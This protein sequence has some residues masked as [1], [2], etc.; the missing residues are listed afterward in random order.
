MRIQ[1]RFLTPSPRILAAGV[2]TVLL[3]GTAVSQQAAAPADTLEEVTVTGVR[4]SLERSLLLKKDSIGVLDA[5]SSEDIGKFPDQNLSESLQRIPGVTVDRTTGGEGQFINVRGLGPSFTRVELNGMTGTSAD[6]GRL[7]DFRSLPAELFQ[8]AVVAKSPNASMTEGGIAAVVQLETPKPL[9][10]Q[11]LKLVGTAEG[12]RGTA[13]KQTEPRY[14]ALIS[15]NWNDKLGVL[16]SAGYSKTNFQTDQTSFGTWGAYRDVASASDLATLPASVLDAAAP[17][18]TGYY[19]LIEQRTNKSATFTVQG[20]PNDALDITF[21]SLYSKFDGALI[22]DRPDAPAE[23][24]QNPVLSNYT[25]QN[26]VLTS[27]TFSGIQ[28]RI[29]TSY[30]PEAD[31][32]YQVALHAD[33]RPTADWRISP[34]LGYSRRDGV[35]ELRLY[36]FAINGAD[37]TYKITNGYPDFTSSATTF[38]SNPQDYGF[39]VFYFQRVLHTDKEGTAKLDFERKF[40]GSAMSSVQFGARY[41][42]KNADANT[43]SAYMCPGCGGLDPL[44]GTLA[45]VAITRPFYVRGMPGSAPSQILAVNPATAEST[46][47]PGLDPYTN[48]GFGGHDP[49]SNALGRFSISEATFAGYIQ[50]NVD[51]G[52]VKMDYGVRI[53]NTD[54]KSSGSQTIDGVLSPRVVSNNY[55]NFLPSANLR[56]DVGHNVIVRGTYAR[57]MTRPELSDLSPTSTIES[58]TRT[59]ARGN[60]QLQPY[61][62][63]QMDLGAEW[64]FRDQAYLAATAYVKRLDSLI[65]QV[66]T[67][68][69]TTF[70]D[71]A[72][73]KTITA[74]IA[75][76]EP[77][78]GNSATVKG[79]EMS[80]QVPFFFLPSGLDKFGTQLNYT[81]AESKASFNDASGVRTVSLPGLSKSSYNAVLFYDDGRLDGRLAYA[82]RSKFLPSTAAAGVSGGAR[83]FDAYGQLDGSVNFR[84]MT[85]VKISLD[86][87]NI[88]N[89]QRK[90]VTALPGLA[91]LVTNILQLERRYQVGARLS[92]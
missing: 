85:N 34:Y 65:T 35:D 20:R 88:T 48:A 49:I 4:A 82:W 41:A 64:Y 83:Y 6:G 37:L 54:E 87:L 25:V 31:K 14:F 47:M 1:V 84:V 63:D 29:G 56:Y 66:T 69:T 32:L 28:N 5:I 44:P 38:A 76:T 36:S 23:S 92:F 90:E 67:N 30:K 68:E 50:A 91:D 11:G 62:A 58:G 86:C 12:T 15:N 78:N 89:E 79:L 16:L 61:T 22:N 39:N 26:G 75:F 27:G 2:F 77:R 51:F 19:S 72:T 17:R 57:T 55:T 52:Q 21:D 80:F 59:G 8:T 7:F 74:P 40:D 60:P 46:F 10:S 43:V 9:A 81:Y 18:T 71:V 13:A 33:W 53:V 45:N 3:G 73:G 42:K 24:G 70:V